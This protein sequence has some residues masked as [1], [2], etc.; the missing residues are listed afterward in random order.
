MLKH[1]KDALPRS[2]FVSIALAFIGLPMGHYHTEPMALE[3]IRSFVI[4]FLIFLAVN[5][6]YSWIMERAKLKKR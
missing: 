6:F 4:T 2:C 1:I 3:M 5:T